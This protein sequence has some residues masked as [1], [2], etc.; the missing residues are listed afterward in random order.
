MTA[1][2]TKKEM[3][4]Q[5]LSHLKDPNEIAFIKHEIELL[6]KKSASNRK[7]TAN[8]IENEGYTEIILNVLRASTKGLSISEIQA[9]DPRLPSSNQRM[10]RLLNNLVESNTVVKVYEK[11]KPYFSLAE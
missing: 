11:R 5:I 6:E 3:F 1:K 2:I 8:Q 4:T 9:L 10:S 7:P